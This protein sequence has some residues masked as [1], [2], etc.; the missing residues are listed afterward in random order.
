MFAVLVRVS[1]DLA[2]LWKL[3]HDKHQKQ[4]KT[5]ADGP[6]D[7]RAILR[8]LGQLFGQKMLWQARYLLVRGGRVQ[9]DRRRQNLLVAVLSQK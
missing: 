4:A 3:V 9:S 5:V 1:V 6:D 2:L 7:A 8:L